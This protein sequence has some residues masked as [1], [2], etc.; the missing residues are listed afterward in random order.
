MASEELILTSLRKLKAAGLKGAPAEISVDML[1]AWTEVFDAIPDVTF[2]SLVLEYL[3]CEEF[4]PAPGSLYKLAEKRMEVNIELAWRRVLQLSKVGQ[5]R[6]RTVTL[7]DEEIEALDPETRDRLNGGNQLHTLETG[8]D[9]T[10][11]SDPLAL[12]AMSQMENLDTLGHRETPPKFIEGKRFEF[13]RL[14]RA[15]FARGYR[16]TRWDGKPQ[17]IHAE[18][19]RQV[20]A[21]T[22]GK[23]PALSQANP[24][25]ETENFAG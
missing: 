21:M 2:N 5:A 20:K 1:E 8:F 16:L 14:Y 25:F 9:L 19:E 7:S 24:S 23:A 22:E 15:A 4:F 3:K 11:I 17:P 18:H 6:V 12:W 10:H 13:G